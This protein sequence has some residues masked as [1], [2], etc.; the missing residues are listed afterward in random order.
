MVGRYDEGA[1]WFE[2][3]MDFTQR[4]HAVVEVMDHQ[5]HEREVEAVLVQPRER[6]GEVVDPKLGPIRN[7]SGGEGHHVGILVEP[8]DRPPSADDLFCVESRAT[9]K[10]KHTFMRDWPENG[11]NGRT[12][13]ESVVCADSCMPFV[14]LGTHSP[15]EVRRFTH[16]T[17]LVLRRLLES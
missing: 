1:T 5:C 7:S 11:K 10:I 17:S 9:S 6:C 13:V 12:I 15:E 14:G 2:Y 3:P 8:D 16:V 4:A